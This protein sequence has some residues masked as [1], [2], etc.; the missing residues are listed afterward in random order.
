MEKGSNRGLW[1]N[2]TPTQNL[3]KRFKPSSKNTTSWIKNRLRHVT[4][5]LTR[6]YPCRYQ[7]KMIDKAE[8]VIYRFCDNVTQNAEHW[9]YSCAAQ[10]CKGLKYLERVEISLDE[11]GSIAPT[12]ISS[13]LDL[14]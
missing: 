12:E 6:Y 2:N 11:V 7:L 9:L 3:M 13:F 8:K 5:L 4:S 1:K 10:F 14:L